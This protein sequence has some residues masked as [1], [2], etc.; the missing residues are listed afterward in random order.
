LPQ[1]KN[2]LITT[3]FGIDAALSSVFGGPSGL[4]KL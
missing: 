1:S 4:S 2:G 3:D